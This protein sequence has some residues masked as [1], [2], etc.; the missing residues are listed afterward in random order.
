MCLIAATDYCVEQSLIDET[1]KIALFHTEMI[2]LAALF[3]WG[4]VL[5]RGEIQND[6]KKFQS[7]KFW[8]RPL[9]EIREYAFNTNEKIDWEVE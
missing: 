3:L 1:V 5:P 9:F 4:N 6:A 8:E 2:A 7:L